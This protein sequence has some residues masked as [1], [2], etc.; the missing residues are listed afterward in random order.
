MRKR[1][2]RIL[3]AFTV[4]CYGHK[5]TNCILPNTKGNVVHAAFVTCYARL[6]LY[7]KL[8]KPLGSR[9]LYMDTDSAFY[10]S[11]KEEEEFEPELGNY[12]G[13]LTNVL[14]DV[15]D[16]E[17]CIISRFCS[18]S[19]KNYGFDVFSEK[20]NEKIKTTFKLR[21]LGLNRETEKTFG[22]DL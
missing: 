13:E 18:G 19:P 21:G 22:I 10:L 2:F 7:V 6:H 3:N 14:E 11:Q 17:S 1:V 4:L 16:D 15:E 5:K 12:L 20:K 9:V 8:P